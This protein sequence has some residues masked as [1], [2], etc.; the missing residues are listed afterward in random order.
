[1]RRYFTALISGNHP[2]TANHNLLT[3]AVDGPGARVLPGQ[4]FLV[5]VN[6]GTD[7][8]LRRAFSLFRK[9]PDGFQ[10]LYRVQGKGTA[11]LRAMREGT[12]IELI[13]PLG[14]GYPHPAPDRTLLVVAGGIGI[15]SVYSL[16][17]AHAPKAVVSYGARSADELL[18][19]NEIRNICRD[20]LISTDDGSA[21]TPGSVV[22]MVR[23]YLDAHP[24]E[25]FE[26]YSCGPRGMLRSLAGLAMDRRIPAYV[27]LEE[28]M[29]CGVGA[30]LG[31]VVPVTCAAQDDADRLYRRVCK[32]G[33]VFD[34]REVAWSSH[35]A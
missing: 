2:L 24:E 29:A 15:A 8:L 34:V 6:K 9:T 1:M 23:R 14:N 32:E 5:E 27:S 10:I 22:E 16:I 21:G 26:I 17:E 13:G 28:H 19:V 33:P 25:R 18:M 11:L 12:E 3:L 7:P 31:C 30:C 35:E 20:L 4:F